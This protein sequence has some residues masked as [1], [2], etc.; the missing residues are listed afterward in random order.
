MAKS[1]TGLNNLASMQPGSKQLVV[2]GCLGIESYK[3]V[4]MRCPHQI[5]RQRDELIGERTKEKEKQGSADAG[6]GSELWQ[7][8][9]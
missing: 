5:Q 1:P 9:V 6:A 7:F 4:V 3:E 8:S 2:L